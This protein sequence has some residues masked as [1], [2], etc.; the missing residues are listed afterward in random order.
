V[1]VL[2]KLLIDRLC[3]APPFL[4]LF[5]LGTA[6]LEGRTPREAWA[7]LRQRFWPALLTNWFVLV[8]FAL[9]PLS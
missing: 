9:P 5:F 6:V 1:P 3:F 2:R 4:V 7:L 8:F